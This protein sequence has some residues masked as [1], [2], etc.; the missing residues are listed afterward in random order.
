M[1]IDF[2]FRP[3]GS[4][5]ILWALAD[6]HTRRVIELLHLQVLREVMTREVEEKLLIVRVG[7][8]SVRQLARPGVMAARFRHYA[9][10]TGGP[11]LHDHVLMSVKVK[12]TDGGWGT[13]V[14]SR[15]A[16]PFLIDRDPRP[17]HR[18][19]RRDELSSDRSLVVVLISV[20]IYAVPPSN[21]VHQARPRRPRVP[22]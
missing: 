13:C 9:S 16:C 12:R 18:T 20:S 15:A 4:I 21:I 22:A 1:A 17:A 8:D 10:R 7:K 11:L 3:P 2:V 6:P 14:G 19:A 5:Q